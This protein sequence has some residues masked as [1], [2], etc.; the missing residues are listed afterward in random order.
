M[1]MEN[2]KTAM[3]AGS[4]DPVTKGHERMII[5]AAGMFDEVVCVICENSPKK[6]MFDLDTRLRMLRAVCEKVS[7]ARADVCY[8]L[9][10]DY[11]RDNGVRYLVRGARN[12]SDFDFE[13]QYANINRHI[14]T[15]D[16]VI[17]P[18]E[19]EYLHI[20]SSFAREL[21]KYGADMSAA[22]PD[23]VV[24]IIKSMPRIK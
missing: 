16:T 23:E 18:S 13:M 24:E 22:L 11:A 20:S 5:R 1:S 14:G 12:G 17:L 15:I 4:F 9:A 19:E 8:G 21:V 2:K 10:V 3:I 7:N 6:Y